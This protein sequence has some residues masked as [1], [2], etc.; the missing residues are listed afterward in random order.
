MKTIASMSLFV[1]FSLP[2]WAAPAKEVLPPLEP[3]DFIKVMEAFET[4]V[5]GAPYQAEAITE[6]TQGLAD[7]NR[8]SRKTKALVYRDGEGRVR[9]EIIVNAIGSMIPHGDPPKTIVIVDP[10]SGTG[11]QLLEEGRI[12]RRIGPPNPRKPPPGPDELPPGPL[13][14]QHHRPQGAPPLPPPVSESLGKQTIEGVEAEGT[15]TTFTIPAGEIGNEKPMQVVHERW[16]SHELQTVVSS[17]R[18]DPRFGVTTYRLTRIT[19]REPDRS[20]FEVPDGYA[21]VDEPRWPPPPP[22]GRRK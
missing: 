7:G 4:V 14:P 22:P 10:A 16:Y 1:L 12:A 13:G 11:Y 19:R 17:T 8:I 5:R 20:L 15:R 6:I 18:N 21:I 2:A 9:R 3:I